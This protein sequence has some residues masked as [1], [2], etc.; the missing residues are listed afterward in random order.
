MANESTRRELLKGGLAVAGL[1][2]FGI[3]D[4]AIP[5]LAQDEIL[6]PFTDIPGGKVNTTPGS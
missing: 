6:V 1:A 4:W 5:V 2:A 3:P